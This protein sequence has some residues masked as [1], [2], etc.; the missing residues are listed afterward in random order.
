MQLANDHPE[1][2]PPER[3]R[4]VRIRISVPTE[5]R[6]E[7]SDVPMRTETSDLSSGGCYV[8]MNLTL[9]E[10]TRLDV[11]LW[12]GDQKTI[13]KGV[14]VTCHPQFGNGIEFVV[15]SPSDRERLESFLETAAHT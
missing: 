6:L 1:P 15:M 11:V 5:L 8:E 9:A 2:R 12:L 10:G 14:V 13:A 7:G 3:R 4:A